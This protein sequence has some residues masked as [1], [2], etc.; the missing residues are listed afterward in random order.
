[1]PW[2]IKEYGYVHAEDLWMALATLWLFWPVVLILHRG[3]SV[4]R[5]VIS[6]TVSAIIL[7][8]AWRE[9][10]SFA[11]RQF[12]VPE[13]VDSFSPT[14]IWDYYAGYRDGRKE[15]ENYVRSGQLTREEIGMPEPE[16]YYRILRDRYQIEPRRM[17]DI[18]T[19]RM[20]GHARGY[21][22]VS[23]PLI[24]RKFGDDVISA[25][26]DETIKHWKE[27]QAKQDP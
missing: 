10:S 24:E 27:T 13:G 11:P 8:P 20:I 3:S 22:D 2:N 25:V 21:N 5:V 16:E 14:V 9:Y 12:G 15:A 4:P 26:R 7:W 1:M 18:V 19:T 17:G 23:D 6:L